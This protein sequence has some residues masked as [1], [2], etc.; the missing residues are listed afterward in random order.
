MI[1]TWYYQATE[2]LHYFLSQEG[3]SHWPEIQKLARDNS[4]KANANLEKYF[5]EALRLNSEQVWKRTVNA[6]AKTFETDGK[7]VE[8]KQD[9]VLLIASPPKPPS[10]P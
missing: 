6:D 8:P 4:G 5:M 7:T 1:L 2:V 3:K 9:V 10:T